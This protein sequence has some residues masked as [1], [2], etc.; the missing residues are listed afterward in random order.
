[1]EHHQVPVSQVAQT[2]ILIV[3]DELLVA[4][5]LG[6][7]LSQLGYKING[8]ASSGQAALAAVAQTPPDLVLMDVVIKG[9]MDG[10]E[11]AQ[12]IHAMAKIPIIFL[13]AYC[14]DDLINRATSSGSYG[15]MIK[16]VK[17]QE[18]S[19]MIKMTLNQHHQYMKLYAQ[20][21]RNIL[22]GVMDQHHIQERLAIEAVRAQ[23]N[24]QTLG[25]IVLSIDQ[26]TLIDQTYGDEAKNLV[27]REILT[28]LNNVLPQT[29]FI[30]RNEDNQIM[31]LLTDCTL[32][33]TTNTA[34][35]IRTDSHDLVVKYDDRQIWMSFSLGVD[36][37]DATGEIPLGEVIEAAIFG[38]T[39]AQRNGGN[40]V[41]IGRPH[42][43]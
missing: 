4:R 41:V 5:Q 6:K 13:T 25:I 29:D 40:R 23:R 15:Y 35:K 31:I 10:I 18:L 30:Y 27:F 11:T 19:A 34:E 39:Q 2:S 43:S 32:D 42:L 38:L 36:C 7:R 26:L 22:T 21:S 17:V 20:N 16:P 33:K 1:M 14:D 24:H 9:E 8:I 12:R 28:H 3:E 37:Y